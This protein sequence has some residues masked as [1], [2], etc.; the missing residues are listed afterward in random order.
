MKQEFI[1]GQLLKKTAV[2]VHETHAPVLEVHHLHVRYNGVQ[3]LEDI[4][5]SLARGEYVALVGPNG[6]GK[7]TLLKAI[8]GLIA[9]ESGKIL[10][11]GHG[12]GHH[13][14]ISYLPQRHQIDWN[15]PVTV[16]DAVMMGRAGRLG[17]L[18]R[19]KKTDRAFVQQCLDAVGLSSLAR[20]Q[21][22]ELSGGQQQ[23]M[24]IARALAQGTELML[25]DEPLS[26]VDAPSQKDIL[27]SLHAL[28]QRGI[29]VI[30]ATHDLSL[31]ADYFDRI[32]L[33]NRR[34]TGVG[35]P[36]EV[37]TPARL[38]EAYG[39]HLQFVESNGKIMALGDTCCDGGEHKHG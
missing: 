30:V 3:A 22:G 2:A 15:F 33:L 37:L 18:H 23:R 1:P 14:C 6:A 39:G 11:F 28:R 16:F 32:L 26:G 8:A 27:D 10:I 9:S 4:S 19:P 36:A 21:I 34:L 17:L 31:A 7:S 20:R 38:L 13:I 35:R 12:P 29:T 5:F 24:F 25:L